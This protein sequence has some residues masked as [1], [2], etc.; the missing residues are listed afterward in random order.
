MAECAL[1]WYRAKTDPIFGLCGPAASLVWNHRRRV[2]RYDG[3]F[4]TNVGKHELDH[5]FIPPQQACTNESSP[6]VIAF[7]NG[8]A[9]KVSS[10]PC[11]V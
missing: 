5:V 2:D 7:D 3:K 11:K 1:A 10:R 8:G 4:F 6:R 9:G